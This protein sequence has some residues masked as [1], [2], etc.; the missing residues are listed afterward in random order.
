MG[1]FLVARVYKAGDAWKIRISVS[2]KLKYIVV[3]SYLPT[4]TTAL[5]DGQQPKGSGF[6]V[7]LWY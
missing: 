7:L 1:C 6:L 3:A 2:I 4:A 5:A